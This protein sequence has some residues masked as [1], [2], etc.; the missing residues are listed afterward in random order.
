MVVVVDENMTQIN[1][2]IIDLGRTYADNMFPVS[3]W[4]CGPAKL[5]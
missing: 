2:V 3:S 1:I 4:Y 5:E